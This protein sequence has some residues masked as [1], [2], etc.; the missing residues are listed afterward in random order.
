MLSEHIQII[1]ST[2]SD[3]FGLYLK[4]QTKTRL[5]S[6][7]NQ[8]TFRVIWAVLEIQTKTR[9]HSDHNQYIFRV[10]WAVLEIQTKTRLHS[11][12]NQYTFM[13]SDLGCT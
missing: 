3:G 8:Y 7:H 2:H 4:I 6:D 13:Q 9:L 11:D 12:H 5:H 1:T 10:I